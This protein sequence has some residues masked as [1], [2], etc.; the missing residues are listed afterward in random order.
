MFRF[1]HYVLLFI[2]TDTY[3]YDPRQAK[4]SI[5]FCSLACYCKALHICITKDILGGASKII[6]TLEI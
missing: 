4:R 5:F 3:I 1:I 6:Y 2:S